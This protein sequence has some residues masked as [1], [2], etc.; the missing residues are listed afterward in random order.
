MGGKYVFVPLGEEN[1]RLY[2]YM[3]SLRGNLEPT[4]TGLDQS[5]FVTF[6]TARDIARISA[7]QA[8]KPL[9]IPEGSVSAVMVRVQPGQDAHKVAI[10]ILQDVQGVT[11][12]ESPNLFQSYRRQMRGA[13]SASLWAR[14]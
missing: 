13:A 14:G 5:L 2:G 1:I 6:E 9:E 4:G 7:K 3:V 8:E 10:K 12:I 11:P